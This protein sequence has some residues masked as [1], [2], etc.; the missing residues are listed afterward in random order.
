MRYNPTQSV[1]QWRAWPQ[2]II[3]LETI[4]VPIKQEAYVS[5]GQIVVVY[6]ENQW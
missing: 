2:K 5:L 1:S 3:K 6:L 4:N